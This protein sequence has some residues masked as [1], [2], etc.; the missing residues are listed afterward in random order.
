MKKLIDS[1]TQEVYIAVS[2]AKYRELQK[3]A[4]PMFDITTKQLQALCTKICN[5]M[6]ITRDW[7]PNDDPRPWGCVLDY[8]EEWYCDECPVQ[9][10]CPSKEKRWSK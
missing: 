1:D 4:K 9:Q 6:P 5:E 10:I 2:E 3:A 7:A 8:D